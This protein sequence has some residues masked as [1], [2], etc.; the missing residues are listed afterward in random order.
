[1]GDTNRAK[2]VLG[3]ILKAKSALDDGFFDLCDLLTEASDNG[4]HTVFGYARFGDWVEENPD[5]DMSARQAYYYV[6]ISK[7]AKQLGLTRDD[8]KRAKISKLKEIFSLEP[9]EHAEEMKQ[10][11]G[12]AAESGLDEIKEKVRQIKVKGGAEDKVHMTLKL[13]PADKETVQQALELARMIYGDVI[14][15]ATGEVTE[16]SD[17]QCVH[18]I[19]S[20]F[21]LDPNNKPEGYEP[22]SVEE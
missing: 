14:N 15:Q 1:V 7:K 13:D 18:L 4:Y 2:E 6:S 17:S 21:L 19:C 10:L 3:L 16:A 9:N 8:L 11:V 20:Q 5:L 22:I 12:E